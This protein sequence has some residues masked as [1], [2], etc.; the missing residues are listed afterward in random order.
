MLSQFLIEPRFFE[1]LSQD[2]KKDLFAKNVESVNIETHSVCNRKCWFCPGSL[3][4]RSSS[5]VL[6]GSAN[7]TKI[8]LDLQEISYDGELALSYNNEPLLVQKKDY[9]ERVVKPARKMLPKTQLLVNTNGDFLDRER[10][11]ILEDSGVDVVFVSLYGDYDLDKPF[12]YKTAAEAIAKFGDKLGI[13][14]T[15]TTTDNDLQCLSW[16]KIGSISL[17]IAAHNHRLYSIDKGNSLPQGVPIPRRHKREKVCGL[18]YVNISIGYDGLVMGCCNLRSEFAGHKP[19]IMG[20]VNFQSIFDI[21]TGSAFTKFR[22]ERLSNINS[23][24]CNT[25]RYDGDTA[26]CNTPFGAFKDRPRT[27]R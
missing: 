1:T 13:T 22:L 10:L 20:N 11:G 17:S 9:E 3:F 2:E 14:P 6:L 7:I 23:Y 24:P 18:P 21:Y 12:I 16:N 15:L 8:L 4:D 19:L 5:N 27:R 25:C 26:I